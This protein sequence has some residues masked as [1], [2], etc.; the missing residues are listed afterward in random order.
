MAGL[1]LDNPNYHEGVW[2]LDDPTLTYTASA[3]IVDIDGDNS[4]RAGQTGAVITTTGI[5]AASVTQS[6]TLGGETLTITG[7]S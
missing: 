7:W 5:D 3:T 4:V 6:V 1:V 2:I